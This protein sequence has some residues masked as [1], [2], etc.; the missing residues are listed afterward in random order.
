MMTSEPPLF[1]QRL[2]L[3]VPL[4]VMALEC[5]VLQSCGDKKALVVQII[6]RSLKHGLGR[7]SSLLLILNVELL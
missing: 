7:T 3:G 4:T 5:W 6:K 1:M 2:T